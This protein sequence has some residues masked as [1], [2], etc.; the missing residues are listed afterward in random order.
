MS[1]DHKWMRA[2]LTYA[3]RGLGRVAPNPSV[4]CLL[5]KNNRLI[6]RA[7]TAPGGRPHAE[8]QALDMAGHNARGACAYVTLEPCAHI[9]K[10]PPCA[11]ALID[12]GVA[13][14]VIALGDPDSRVAGK[15]TAMLRAAG[16]EV[17]EDVLAS[18]AAALNA[19]YLKLRH[20]GLPFVTL[21]LAQTLDGRIATAAGESQWITG[22]E[23]RLRGHGLR[24][25]HD[26]MLVGSGTAQADDPAL[27]SRGFGPLP[28]QPLRVVF[29]SGVHLAP[30]AKLADV[31][32]APTLIYCGTNADPSRIA[33]LEALGVQ[34]RRG[35]TDR[36]DPIAAL[37]DLGAQGI[38]RV[39]CEG[40]GTLAASLIKAGLVDR[41]ALFSAGKLIGADGRAGLGDL[42]LTALNQAPHFTLF[43]Q[44]QLGPDTLSLWDASR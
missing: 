24:A 19:G 8:T 34:V 41:I 10:T 13:R 26:A 42:G 32:M 23:A 31:S 36:V 11:Q 9:G 39:L 5:V 14:V 25:Q 2:A 7:H 37:K 38:T 18:D 6:A 43:A 30:S 33:K 16:I 17:V 22:P 27:T 12:A 15:G 28:Q 1:A 44:E 20:Q 29:D 21:K 4:A 35:D 40:G 3:A